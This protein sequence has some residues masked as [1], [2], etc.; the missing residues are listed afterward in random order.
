MARV[1]RTDDGKN[2]T[3]CQ[4]V[5][6]WGDFGR[7]AASP[8]GFQYHCR[9]CQKKRWDGLPA[10]K[11]R[12]YYATHDARYKEA[13]REAARARVA[14]DPG[15]IRRRNLL[16][17]YGITSEDFDRMLAEQGGGCA[18]CGATE[19]RNGRRLHVDHCH[20]TGKVRGI[21]CEGCNKGLGHFAD[22]VDRM[23]KATNYLTEKS[24]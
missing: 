4:E 3:K 15:L 22:N 18:I 20:S 14:A 7:M 16:Y 24:G 6:R 17:E 11:R 13:R 2:C 12:G 10:E 8:D 5:K 1:V 19:H 21:L 23:I 9:D